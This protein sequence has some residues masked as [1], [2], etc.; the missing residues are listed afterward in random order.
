MIETLQPDPKSLSDDVLVGGSGAVRK[1]FE[2]AGSRS[3]TIRW[4]PRTADLTNQQ[5]REFARICQSVAGPDGRISEADFDIEVFRAQYPW[6]MVLRVEDDGVMFRYTYYGEGIAAVRGKSML[7]ETTAGFV[8]HIG[9]FFT[10]VYRAIL[11]RPTWLLTIHEPP[12]EV[13]ARNWE[14]LIVPVVDAAG[15]VTRIVVMNVP[16]NELRAGLEIIPDPVMILDENQVVRFAN[17][18]ARQMFDRQAYYHYDMTLFDYTGINLAIDLPPAIL[19]RNRAV[20]DK[21]CL[22]MRNRLLQDFLVTISG[23][24]LWGHPFYVITLRM[25][26]RSNDG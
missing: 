16:D 22:A 24:E 20:H 6:L 10:S 3:P 26:V 11:Q 21:V 2:D 1:L 19:V 5:I 7:G 4:S 15:R 17:K 12:K 14:R 9:Q 8:G 23:A 25:D 18:A 13:F